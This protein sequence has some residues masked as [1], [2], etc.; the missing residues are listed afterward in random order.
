MVLQVGVEG[1]VG[2]QKMPTG[3]AE[4]DQITGGGLPRSR[5]TLVVG[6]PGSGKTVFALQTL[7]NGVRLRGEPALFVALEENA[8]QI[9]ANAAT[10]AWDPSA[11][12]QDKLYFLDARMSLE[13]V[14]AGRFDLSGLLAGLEAKAAEIGARRIAFDSLDVLLAVL[15]N[16]LQERLETY[17]LHDWLARSHL[18]GI[19]TLRAEEGGPPAGARNGFM[20]FMA[21]CVI[22]LSQR[23]ED[24]VSL[25]TLRVAKYRGSRFSENEFPFILGT[26]GVELGSTGLAQAVYAAPAERVSS[27]VERLDHMLR[28]GVYR[29]S[30]VLI[31]GAPGTAKSTLCGAFIEAACRRGERCLYVS[32]DE[33]AAE[34]VRNFSSVNV[35]L[36]PHVESGLLRIDS[37]WSHSCSADEHLTRLKRSIAEHQPR[38]MAID[39]LS[40]MMKAGGGLAAHSMADRLLSLAQSSTITLYCTSLVGGEHPEAETTDLQVST[41]ADTWV[42]LSYVVNGGER[43]RALTIVKSRGTGHSSQVRELVLSDEG[44]TLADVYTSGGEVLMGTLRWEHEDALRAKQE[45]VRAEWERRSRELELSRAET[46][47]RMEVIRRELEQIQAEGARLETERRAAEAGWRGRHDEIR[48]LRGADSGPSPSGADEPDG[49]PGDQETKAERA[50][51]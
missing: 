17:R 22:H 29:G 1:P 47:A 41:I 12:P 48:S 46:Q 32:F 38:C 51:R 50:G 30:S 23:L 31:T 34:L 18:T 4:F 13:T 20:Q 28:G 10:F 11:L 26:E 16:P 9:V 49:P 15:D 36:R 25:R 19:I 27:G 40:A 5:T 3:I 14:T 39:P 35:Q 2:L 44:I 33:T 7:V 21:D 37:A 45:Q 8:R 6:A 43:N 42:H 24:R